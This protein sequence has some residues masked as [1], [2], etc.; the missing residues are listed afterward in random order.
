MTYGPPATQAQLETAAELAK[1]LLALDA[2]IDGDT[3]ID[4]LKFTHGDRVTK[5]PNKYLTKDF[6]SGSIGDAIAEINRIKNNA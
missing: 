2:D 3:A 4:L 1:E 5:N 6:L